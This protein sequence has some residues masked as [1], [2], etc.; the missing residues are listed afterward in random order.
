[1]FN[2][3]V[4]EN[5]EFGNPGSLVLD[6]TQELSF[7]ERLAVTA[8]TGHD[9]TVFVENL[10]NNDVKI[11]HAQGE[12]EFAGSVLVGVIWQL[13]QMKGEPTNA[14]NCKRGKVV[15][16]QENDV[17]WLRIGTEG[18]LG[19]WEYEQL[20]SPDA[21]EAIQVT[22][23]DG[24]NKMVWAWIDESRGLIRARTFANKIGI[25]EVQ[26]NGS[27]SMNLASQLQREITITH[28]DGSI[29]YARPSA[30]NTAELGGRVVGL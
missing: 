2:V 29:I 13:G 26:G 1:M 16:W 17:Y 30:G 20:D 18:N 28:G 24:W 25:P 19:N 9:E 14:I 6:E 12:V 3:F 11:Y 4:N 27:G 10:E 15:T 7:E 8:G 22:D 23:T 21:V 5:G